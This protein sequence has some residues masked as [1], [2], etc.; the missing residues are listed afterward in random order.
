MI[1]YPVS[2]KEYLKLADHNIASSIFDMPEVWMYPLQD[3]K[4][5]ELGGHN[6]KKKHDF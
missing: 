4:Y 5:K 2:D 3:I 6:W 1:K